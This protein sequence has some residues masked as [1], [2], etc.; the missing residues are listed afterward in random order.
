M[1]NSHDQTVR[2]AV[3]KATEETATA[4][5][6]KLTGKEASALR[7][8]LAVR[9]GIP[10]QLA[11]RLKGD[12]E[13]ELTADAER[14]GAIAKS[15]AP[16][17]LPAPPVQAQPASGGTPSVGPGNFQSIGDMMA[18]FTSEVIRRRFES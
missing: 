15:S 7:G 8:R 12:T 9:Y 2:A 4:A 11:D 18:R 13:A 1:S 16:A 10:I 17:Q 6:K 3:A 5:Q 14:L